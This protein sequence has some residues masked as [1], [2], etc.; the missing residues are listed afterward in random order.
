MR[1][2][3]KPAV[4]VT[5]AILSLAGCSALPGTDTQAGSIS[6]HAQDAGVSNKVAEEGLRLLQTHRYDDAS[7]VFNAGLKFFPTDARLH[8]LNGFAYHLLYLAGR[9]DAL[10]LAHD[11]AF[12]YAA[13][14]LGRL[15][16]E[17]KRYGKSLE[18][19]SRA[20]KIEPRN[21]EAFVG[22]ASAAYY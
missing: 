6:K 3:M 11:P 13:L 12:Y 22:I 1:P 18:A 10:A 2:M 20:L 21:G 8:F 19:F 9:Q 16:F 17:A 14:Q 15:Q 7:R 4:L 5:A